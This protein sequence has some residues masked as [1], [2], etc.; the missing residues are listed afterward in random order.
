[1]ADS[2]ACQRCHQPL[3][4]DA[5]VANLTA[6]Q[7][8]LIANTLPAPPRPSALAPQAKLDA[9]PPASRASAAA[10][11]SANPIAESYVLL[12]DRAPA[13][14]QARPASP[15]GNRPRLAANLEALLSART[16]I[17]HPLC[18][19]CT[20]LFQAELQ[21][22]LEEL[23]RERD[24]YIAFERGLRKD[25]APE[26][27]ALTARRAALED[28]EA[29]LRIALRLEEDKLRLAK[30]EE[31]RVRAD[32][33]A[34]ERDEAA[35]LKSHAALHGDMETLANQLASAKTQLLLSQQLLAHL[36]STNV[37]NDAF[38]IG[39]A[40]L[41]NGHVGT[42][43]GLRLGG[44]PSVDFDEINAAWGL[45]A[46]CIDRLAVRV[47]YSFQRYKIIPLGSFSRIEDLPGRTSYELYGSGD[48][49]PGRLWQNRQFSSGLV[50]L[51]DCLRQLLEHGRATGR[52]WGS[53]VEISKDRINGHSVRLPGITSGLPGFGSVM[54]LG[55]EEV[56]ANPDEQWTRACRAV[57]TALKRILVVESE[58]ERQ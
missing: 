53:G 56:D 52:A 30:E 41:D 8:A 11:A 13:P 25:G 32:E 37:Y 18:T 9:L 28:E 10:W 43:N 7:Y 47:G 20:G 40:P 44:R 19:E 35:F 36:E 24:A 21:R 38:Q 46:L 55:G 4:R 31:A 57:L 1:M 48:L 50:A 54:G 6:S 3:L 49:T 27:D 33:E 29:G 45:V 5:S 2:L 15:Q 58:A 14:A 39:H 34:V 22:E 12:P 26:W 42:I 16:A 23:T 51:L 17:D